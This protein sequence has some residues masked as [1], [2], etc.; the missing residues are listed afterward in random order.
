MSLVEKFF[1]FKFR[2]L[3]WVGLYIFL[4]FVTLILTIFIRGAEGGEAGMILVYLIGWQSYLADWGNEFFSLGFS[5]E[6]LETFGRQVYLQFL[7]SISLIL[8]ITRSIRRFRERK[9]KSPK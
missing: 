5:L 9:E 1:Y 8:I 2:D 7:F 3:I 6:T 4:I